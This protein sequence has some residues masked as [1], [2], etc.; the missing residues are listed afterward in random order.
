M[1]ARLVRLWRRPLFEARM[2]SATPAPVPDS[3]P[4]FQDDLEYAGTSAAVWC[5]RRR[6]SGSLYTNMPAD[7]L[8]RL[9]SSAANHERDTVAAAERVLRHEF[10]LLGSGPF[11]PADPER[12]V[13]G[14][15]QPIDWYLD[16][17]RHLRFPRGVPHKQWNLYEMRPKNADI[18]YPWELGRCQHW[19]TLGQAFQLTGDER[20]AR[21]IASELDDFVEANPVGVGVN[22]TCTMDVALR[23]VSWANGLELVRASRGLDD[24][25]WERAYSALFDHGVFIRNNLENTYEV[26]SN[27]FLSNIVGLQFVGAIFAGLPQAEAWTTFAREAL[28]QEIVVQVLPDGADYESSIPYHR[29]VTELFLGA[30]RLADCQGKPLS[31]DY[32]ARVRKMVAYL[33]AVTRPDGLMPQVG[34]ADDGR[35]H[36]FDGYGTESPQDGRHLFGPASAM[37]GDPAWLRLAGDAGAWEAAWWGLEVERQPPPPLPKEW[38]GDLFPNAGVAVARSVG[39]HYLIATNG[40]VGTNGFG[41]HKHND[42]LSFEYHHRGTPL[43]VDPGSYVYT[44]DP[45]ARNQF[46]GTAFHNTVCIDGVEQNELRPDWLFRLFETSKAEHVAFEDRADAFEYAGRHHGYERLPQPVLHERTLRLLKPS[47]EL[48]IVDRLCGAGEHDVWW[49][50]HLAPGV[51]AARLDDTTV[52]LAAS[53]DRWQFTIPPGLRIAIGPSSY[54][55]SYGV[56]LPCVALNISSRVTL[57]GDRCYEFVISA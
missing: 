55:P 8:A 56:M 57:A 41:N 27:H 28:E 47:G 7:T 18:K 46:R 45:D 51:A 6:D 1:L 19:V 11:V 26:T 33:A 21:E 35:L 40:V 50:F 12:P 49:H 3:L 54:S 29:L 53:G 24:A 17:V 15:Y 9:R 5:R 32:R 48:V 36:I 25:F 44:S 22:W 4:K 42:Q 23:A 39:G 38:L 10:N 16:P 13:R 43:I 52:T 30:A 2:S 37:F 31:D 14:S 20:F 34:D